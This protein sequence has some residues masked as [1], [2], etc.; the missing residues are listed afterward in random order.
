MKKLSSYI[1]YLLAAVLFL[2]GRLTAPQPDKE[3][4]RKYEVERN[5]HLNQIDK[6]NAQADDLAKAGIEIGEK[7]E[8][9]R[10]KDSIALKAKDRVIFKL[11][12]NYENISFRNADAVKLDSIFAALY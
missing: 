1:P 10:V 2:V 12:Q 4:L 5:Y 8:A 9:R 3:L 6:L 7:M 11:K